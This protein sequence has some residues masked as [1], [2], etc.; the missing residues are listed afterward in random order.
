MSGIIVQSLLTKAGVSNAKI[1]ISSM[2]SGRVMSILDGTLL[3]DSK[4]HLY[5]STVGALQYHVVTRQK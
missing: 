3:D 5:R 4:A 1:V 2:Q